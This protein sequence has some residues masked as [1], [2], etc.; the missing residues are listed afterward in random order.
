[1][2]NFFE[3]KRGGV[4]AVGE[5]SPAAV[6]VVEHAHGAHDGE[7]ASGLLATGLGVFELVGFEDLSEPVPKYDDGATVPDPLGKEVAG[8][9]LGGKNMRELQRVGSDG[10]LSKPLAFG[11][12]CVLQV[13][14]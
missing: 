2:G 11:G 1:M 8:H 3:I 5:V 10:R 4:G 12:N 6:G 14:V 13:A 9:E 7:A